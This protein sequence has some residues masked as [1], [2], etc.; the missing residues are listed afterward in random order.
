MVNAN[1]ASWSL[2][3]PHC[4]LNVPQRAILGHLVEPCEFF[5]VDSFKH[6]FVR[7]RVLAENLG[8]V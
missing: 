7:N 8:D 2:S 3:C 4:R 5:E 1:L 6:V